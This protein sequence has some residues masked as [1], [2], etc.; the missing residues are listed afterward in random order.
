MFWDS[1]DG[2]EIST[3]PAGSTLVGKGPDGREVQV[4]LANVR[5]ML[6]TKDEKVSDTV[7][8][9]SPPP[10]VPALPTK[11]GKYGTR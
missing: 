9:P 2:V 1:D 4:P 8:P 5:S 3:G 10:T 11:G 7:P 6:F